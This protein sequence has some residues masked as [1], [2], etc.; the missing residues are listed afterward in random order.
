MS[1]S[2]TQATQSPSAARS[3]EFV[4]D[5]DCRGERQKADGDADP[6]PAQ[7][8]GDPL[9]QGREVRTDPGLLF[10]TRPDRCRPESGGRGL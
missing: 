4:I 5:G 10:A 8:A 3:S 9:T 7:G 2:T 6:Q 1:S